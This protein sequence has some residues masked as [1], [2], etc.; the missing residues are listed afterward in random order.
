M[1]KIGMPFLTKIAKANSKSDSLRTTIPKEVVESFDLKIHDVL[2]WEI[3]EEQ[4]VVKKW[5][6]QI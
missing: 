5:R 1:L 6:G 4:L 2:I 3:K